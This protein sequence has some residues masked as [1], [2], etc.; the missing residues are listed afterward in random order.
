[1]DVSLTPQLEELVRSKVASGRYLD[2]SAVIRQA[3][4]LLDEYEE[5]EALRAAVMIGYE[6]AE[7]GELLPWTPE[8]RAT[9]DRNVAEKAQSGRK[10]KADVLP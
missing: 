4:A 2:A 9:I 5:R 7:R 6:Q 10:P 1:M 3:L 8:L